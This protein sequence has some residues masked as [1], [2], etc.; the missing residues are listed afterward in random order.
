MSSWAFEPDPTQVD[1]QQIVLIYTHLYSD[2]FDHKMVNHPVGRQIWR[3]D[4]DAETFVWAEEIVDLERSGW[5]EGMPITVE[6]RLRWFTNLGEE[7]FRSGEYGAALQ[8]YDSVLAL[9]ASEGWTPEVGQPDWSGYSR[10]RRAETLALL[11]RSDEALADMQAVA[12]GYAGDPLGELAEAF[13]AGYGDGRATDAPARGIAAMQTVD[14]YSHFYYERGGALCFPMEA[15]GILYPGVGL[16]AYLNVHPELLEDAEELQAGLNAIGF[17]F[18]DVRLEGSG[19][20]VEGRVLIDLRLPD[21]PNANG[22]LAT[23]TLARSAGQWRV[24]PPGPA[25]DMQGWPRVGGF[26]SLSLRPL[27]TP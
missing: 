19:G 9:A 7:S 14:L 15:S 16:T 11:G 22:A 6:D 3:W 24:T 10:F 21:A 23:W 4:A 2:G 27:V 5:G 25:E 8:Q 1:L 17:S 12:A 26:D 13:L 18:E 20:V